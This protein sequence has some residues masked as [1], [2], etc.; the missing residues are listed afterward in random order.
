MFCSTKAAGVCVGP[1]K[2][3]LKKI[4]EGCKAKGTG[5]APE[6]TTCGTEEQY[7]I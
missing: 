4:Y 6:P 1:M 7:N 2:M 3:V 5:N